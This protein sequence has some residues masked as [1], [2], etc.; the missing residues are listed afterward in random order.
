MIRK[1]LLCSLLLGPGAAAAAPAPAAAPSPA[2]APAPSP[3][4]APR[5]AAAQAPRSAAAYCEY[6]RGVADS[7]SALL[8]SPSLFLQFGLINGAGFLSADLFTPPPTTLRL[9]AGLKLSANRIYQGVTLRARA[10]SECE[11]YEA[12]SEIFTFLYRSGERVTRGALAARVAALRE[13]LPRGEQALAEVQR[14]FEQRLAT[15]EELDAT[16]VRLDRLRQDLAQAAASLDGLPDLP[17]PPR[18]IRQIL[19]ERLRAEEDVERQAAKLRRAQAWDVNVQAG[20][21]Q[22]FGAQNQT[23][24]FALLSASF[25]PGLFFQPRADARAR[26]A[27]VEWAGAQVEGANQRALRALGDLAA[28]RRSEEARLR[29]VRALIAD[30]AARHEELGALGGKK[31][32]RYRDQ[33]WFELATARAEEAY[34]AVHVEDLAALGAGEAP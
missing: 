27:R 28:L 6:V 20:Y 10:R 29:E 23:P 25:N 24:V 7:E 9:S 32:Q 1:S 11:R 34:L 14:A 3:A 13:A 19:A 21:D 33:V 15:A 8:L 22:V 17:A 18:P 26:A 12:E 30:L 16:R 2:P 4:P 31:V 5:S